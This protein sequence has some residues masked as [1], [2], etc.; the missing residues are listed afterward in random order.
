VGGG[1]FDRL[2]NCLPGFTGT[3][4]DPAEQFVGLAVGVFEV[5]VS[6][7]GP[8]LFQFALGDVPVALGFECIVYS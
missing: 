1:F 8:L 3:R 2:F 5:V 6:E 4:L 7:R